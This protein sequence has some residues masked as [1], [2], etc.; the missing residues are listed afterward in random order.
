MGMLRQQEDVILSSFLSQQHGVTRTRRDA[1]HDQVHDTCHTS[2]LAAAGGRGCD[3]QTKAHSSLS[4]ILRSTSSSGSHG[5]SHSKPSPAARHHRVLQSDSTTGAETIGRPSPRKRRKVELNGKVQLEVRHAGEGKS[6]KPPKSESS[7]SASPGGRGSASLSSFVNDGGKKTDTPSPGG[8]DA[9]VADEKEKPALTTKE[10]LFVPPAAGERLVDYVHTLRGKFSKFVQEETGKNFDNFSSNER[11][12]VVPVFQKLQQLLAVQQWSASGSGPAGKELA[13]QQA[14]AHRRA[15]DSAKLESWNA[16]MKKQ[17]Q[18]RSEQYE[19]RMNLIEKDKRENRAGICESIEAPAD[20][21]SNAGAGGGTGASV[22]GAGAEPSK[23]E[24]PDACHAIKTRQG[25]AVKKASCVWK[26][27]TTAGACNQN[28]PGGAV[29]LEYC[30]QFELESGTGTKERCEWGN[31]K[32]RCTFVPHEDNIVDAEQ[33]APGVEGKKDASTPTVEGGN[34]SPHEGGQEQPAGLDAQS[35]QMNTKK[36]ASADATT[37]AKNI[38]RDKQEPE[39]FCYS[40]SRDDVEFCGRLTAADDCNYH[41]KSCEWVPTEP[42][43]EAKSKK[44][45]PLSPVKEDKAVEPP[46]VGQ[47][48]NANAGGTQEQQVREPLFADAALKEPR[49]FGLDALPVLPRAEEVQP[50]PE[51]ASETTGPGVCKFNDV[52][53]AGAVEECKTHEDELDCVGDTRCTWDT[54]PH[55]ELPEGVCAPAA[56]NGAETA[57]ADCAKHESEAACNAEANDHACHWETRV[58]RTQPPALRSGEHD[59]HQSG[60]CKA[61]DPR[62][63]EDVVACS[64]HNAVP[65]ATKQADRHKLC[66]EDPIC[67]W[68]KISANAEDEVVEETQSQ[69]ESGICE[70]DPEYLNLEHKCV[71]T[72]VKADLVVQCAAMRTK[73][74]CNDHR[75]NYTEGSPRTCIWKD[76]PPGPGS[77]RCSALKDPMRPLPLDATPQQVLTRYSQDLVQELEQLSKITDCGIQK[78]EHEQ[79]K[80]LVGEVPDANKHVSKMVRDGLA[81]RIDDWYRRTKIR[82]DT[83]APDFQSQNALLQKRRDRKKRW[84]EMMLGE[85]LDVK[86]KTRMVHFNDEARKALQNAHLRPFMHALAHKS[87]PD[88]FPALLAKTHKQVTHTSLSDQDDGAPLRCDE[89]EDDEE[90][91]GTNANTPK[92]STTGSAAA[93]VQSGGDGDDSNTT[94]P[95]A[96]ED[97]VVPMTAAQADDAEQRLLRPELE[98]RWRRLSGWNLKFNMQ[99][100]C[101]VDLKVL[102]RS[103]DV[104]TLEDPMR[105]PH[106]PQWEVDEHGRVLEKQQE[107]TAGQHVAREPTE[108]FECAPRFRHAADQEI[109]DNAMAAE[110]G[111]GEPCGFQCKE[112]KCKTQHDALDQP[113]CEWRKVTALSPVRPPDQGKCLPKP[114]VVAALEKMKQP[115]IDGAAEGTTAEKDI[116]PAT[117]DPSVLERLKLQ[118]KAALTGAAS[119]VTG[120]NTAGAEDA[121]TPAV[122]A[123]STSQTASG[124]CF[125]LDATNADDVALCEAKVAQSGCDAESTKCG[126]KS[127]SNLRTGTCTAADDIGQSICRRLNQEARCVG[128]ADALGVECN[129]EGGGLD[130]DQVAPAEGTAPTGMCVSKNRIEQVDEDVPQQTGGGSTVKTVRRIT[131]KKNRNGKSTL[132]MKTNTK[133]VGRDQPT[134][135]ATKISTSDRHAGPPCHRRKSKSDCLAPKPIAA[136]PLKDNDKQDAGTSGGGDGTEDQSQEASSSKKD[137]ESTKANA[138]GGSGSDPKHGDQEQAETEED[139]EPPAPDDEIAEPEECGWI[140][141]EKPKASCVLKKPS[142]SSEAEAA[143]CHSEDFENENTCVANPA[144]AWRTGEKPDGVCVYS[145]TVEPAVEA[146]TPGQAQKG[147]TDADGNS[148]LTGDEEQA[149]ASARAEKNT[150]CLA[151]GD[152]QATCGNLAASNGCGWV[153]FDRAPLERDPPP[154][155]PEEQLRTLQKVCKKHPSAALCGKDLESKD[156]AW[157]PQA[158]TH[159]CTGEPK[160]CPS[161]DEKHACQADPKCSWKKAAAPEVQEG[162]TGG[163]AE[164]DE[165]KTSPNPEDKAHAEKEDKNVDDST[166][167]AA[168]TKEGSKKVQQ[169]QNGAANGDADDATPTN[170]ASTPYEIVPVPRPGGICMS[171][172]PVAIERHDLKACGPKLAHHHPEGAAAS[173][174]GNGLEVENLHQEQADPSTEKQ[175]QEGGADEPEPASGSGTSTEAGEGVKTDGAATAS[176][177]P[178]ATKPQAPKTPVSRD[179]VCETLVNSQD[180]GRAEDAG[181]GCMWYQRQRETPERLQRWVTEELGRFEK[182]KTR[183]IAI[184]REIV[185]PPA[186]A[187]E[188][189]AAAETSPDDQAATEEVHAGTVAADDLQL[190]PHARQP[191]LLT[192]VEYQFQ[193][194]ADEWIRET[195]RFADEEIRSLSAMLAKRIQYAHEKNDLEPVPKDDPMWAEIE[196][197]TA[198]NLYHTEE[199]I[200]K[201]ISEVQRGL[202]VFGKLSFLPEHQS[203]FVTD[204]GTAGNDAEVVG[205]DKDDGSAFFNAKVDEGAAPALTSPASTTFATEDAAALAREEQLAEQTA[206]ANATLV[207]KTTISLTAIPQLLTKKIR[208]TAMDIGNIRDDTQTAGATEVE[209]MVEYYENKLREAVDGPQDYLAPLRAAGEF[210]KDLT[211]DLKD[212]AT[213]IAAVIGKVA[214]VLADVGVEA[215][216]PIKHF[217]PDTTKEY[218][219]L[220]GALQMQRATQAAAMAA[221]ANAAGPATITPAGASTSAGEEA[222]TGAVA[223]EQQTP[224]V[225]T[226]SKE[227]EDL[228][229]YYP[230]KCVTEVV[231]KFANAA[232]AGQTVVNGVAPVAA[233]LGMLVNELIDLL[234]TAAQFLALQNISE[235]PEYWEYRAR[236]PKKERADERI[237]SEMQ[238]MAFSRTRKM[239]PTTDAVSGKSYDDSLPPKGTAM[240]MA[241]RGFYLQRGRYTPGYRGHMLE[242]YGTDPIMTHERCTNGISGPMGYNLKCLFPAFGEGQKVDRMPIEPG[243]LPK[244]MTPLQ[245]RENAVRKSILETKTTVPTSSSSSYRNPVAQQYLGPDFSHVVP[246][247]KSMQKQ[248]AAAKLAARRQ[249]KIEDF[250]ATEGER[251]RSTMEASLRPRVSLEDNRSDFLPTLMLN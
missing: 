57:A 209:Q 8:D 235:A 171:V 107:L 243:V 225:D 240:D 39:G 42:V 76:L 162:K 128:A 228:K 70:A 11:K 16:R 227:L 213:F 134:S 148:T 36:A 63:F 74:T 44:P 142:S 144:C 216:R 106:I 136:E 114:S 72:E 232:K 219:T 215:L 145:A 40:K 85:D 197:N 168:A 249:A 22:D 138:V 30:K 84:A 154:P 71:T 78:L 87:L 26:E 58:E 187:G 231:K 9:D 65:N 194:V 34:P 81:M 1:G 198:S 158:P 29:D 238:R 151:N 220:S 226:L 132:T 131:T 122:A 149:S 7:A 182:A 99:T 167:G 212:P 127:F 20:D 176:S 196:R 177:T 92:P 153:Q 189:T 68:Q 13:T 206:R 67:K 15:L 96:E 47:S 5:G 51:V 56:D 223:E 208:R 69:G 222:A 207:P 108:L 73:Q 55:Q 157:E 163:D 234:Y 139:E 166:D 170:A 91:A 62:N 188:P 179:T 129:W 50:E 32:N 82:L 37:K 185:R 35:E 23:P 221:A 180:C 172:D 230:G 59:Q 183:R 241:F 152:S 237:L 116:E 97:P 14:A 12:D 10:D 118:A 17:A 115:P 86:N 159:E 161:L 218:E 6:N 224:G 217:C 120:G 60:F 203:F 112:Q 93:T 41:S 109:C 143:A 181:A 52:D 173:A 248:A 135:S 242:E 103:L 43:V 95:A 186:P 193:K 79:E 124:V 146:G 201:R 110:R 126:W 191:V 64:F 174:G 49:P 75:Y 211:V 101:G 178:A 48:D 250:L 83:N 90:G 244:Q 125:P 19:S 24:K 94:A 111:N 190:K 80:I 61:E 156:C 236:K 54:Q 53:D 205:A 229:L 25:C 88:D 137:D 46:V 121:D 175:V 4:Q 141:F 140:A 204:A 104:E 169:Q 160:Y 251:I 195:E 214:G 130:S 66:D 21:N 192:P 164:V 102:Q 200:H 18:Y 155:P 3:H 31:N 77:W 239:N 245:Q 150:F 98:A 27:S 210:F 100:R 247:P 38:K 113:L 246:A 202:Q 123:T 105:P 133:V 117:S 2:T 165:N 33:E 147:T 28:K 199:V 119:L 45:P 184:L 89:K 233:T